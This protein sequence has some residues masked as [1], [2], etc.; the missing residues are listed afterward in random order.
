MLTP[1][2]S[3]VPHG[4]QRT[5]RSC[6]LSP[7][8]TLAS[9]HL[10]Y[11]ILSHSFVGWS[12]KTK[13]TALH[14]QGSLMAGEKMQG[15]FGTCARKSH[16]SAVTD[17]DLLALLCRLT[18]A[19]K[20]WSSSRRGFLPAAAEQSSAGRHRLQLCPR[21]VWGAEPAC[22]CSHPQTLGRGSG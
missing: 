1:W 18:L 10:R 15:P 6:Q 2:E 9:F 17:S 22:P 4:V 20:A 3:R 14:L 8:H 13:G 11:S 19:C 7:I 5:T 21:L 16:P 12:W